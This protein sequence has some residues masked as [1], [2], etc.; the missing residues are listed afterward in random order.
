MKIEAK[1]PPFAA[2]AI[3]VPA[4]SPTDSVGASSK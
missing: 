1:S 4:P 3:I 2:S